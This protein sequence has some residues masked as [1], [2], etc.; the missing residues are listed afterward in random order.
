LVPVPDD[1]DVSV[2]QVLDRGVALVED[3]RHRHP[4]LM[5]ALVFAV[6]SVPAVSAASPGQ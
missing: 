2:E 4:M 6:A 1:G 3:L 5:V